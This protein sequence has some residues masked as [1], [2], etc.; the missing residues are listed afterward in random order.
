MERSLQND[1]PVK[2]AVSKVIY[3]HINCDSDKEAWGFWTK[4]YKTP[5]NGI[6]M[7]WVVKP[8]GD[9]A[10][11]KVGGMRGAKLAE[12]LNKVAKDFGKAVVSSK[13]LGQLKAAAKEA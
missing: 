8:N 5:G 3:L 1:A 12:F 10:E 7:W 4:K 6:P 9:L 2:A 13:R 11:S